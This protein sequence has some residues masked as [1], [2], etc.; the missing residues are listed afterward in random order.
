[1]FI[2]LATGDILSITF[3]FSNFHCCK[4]KKILPSGHTVYNS[5]AQVNLLTSFITESILNNQQYRAANYHDILSFGISK[6]LLGFVAALFYSTYLWKV[7]QICLCLPIRCSRF[8]SQLSTISSL[9]F[10]RNFIFHCGMKRTALT[11]RKMATGVSWIKKIINCWESL[12]SSG[13]HMTC[14]PTYL[15]L[16]SFEIDC[17]INDIWLVGFIGFAITTNC[18]YFDKIGFVPYLRQIRWFFVKII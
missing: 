3:H 1:M 17:R 9:C 2:R 7:H 4:F 10:V 16:H 5:N 15:F 18:I 12:L 13:L 6:V 14:P 8:E 11:K